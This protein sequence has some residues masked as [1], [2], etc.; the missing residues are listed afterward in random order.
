MEPFGSWTRTQ[1]QSDGDHRHRQLKRPQLGRYAQMGW[2]ER[3]TPG[4]ESMRRTA[5]LD[6]RA[7]L[8]ARHHAAILIP[9]NVLEVETNTD[10][11]SQ[12]MAAAGV[13]RSCRHDLNPRMLRF[14]R[15]WRIGGVVRLSTDPPTRKWLFKNIEDLREAGAR[16]L[17]ATAFMATNLPQWFTFAKDSDRCRNQADPYLKAA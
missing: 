5:T 9:M 13:L 11:R 4:I 7:G 17:N 15:T 14:S 3:C 2:F 12:R 1:G 8:F 10:R 16:L 6:L